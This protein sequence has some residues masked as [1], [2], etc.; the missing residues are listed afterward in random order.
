VI[1]L[2]L[3]R[4]GIALAAAAILATSAAIFVAALAF[5]LYALVRPAVGPAGAAAVVAGAAALLVLFMGVAAAV[6]ARARPARIRPRGKDSAERIINFFKDT[7][8]TAVTAALAAGVLAVRSPKYL[9]AAVRS[10]LE[11]EPPRRR[12]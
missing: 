8:I 9:G 11:G 2:I 3:G 12:R 6:A 4:V 10:F 1:K 7:P 5:A